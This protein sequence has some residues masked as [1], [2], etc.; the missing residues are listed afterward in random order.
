MALLL[1]I[2]NTDPTTSTDG[3]DHM[4][5][6]LF[7]AAAAIAALVAACSGPTTPDGSGT[8][9]LMLTDALT[10]EVEAVNIY[11]TS[12]TAKPVGEGPPVELALELTPN[13]VNLLTLADTV[14]AFAAAAVE[15]GAYEFIHINID[16]SRSHIV[17][18]G[19]EKALQ[20]PSGEVKILQG[21]TVE[22]NETTEITLD[23][24]ADASLVQLGNGG[25][26]LKPVIV[27]AGRNTTGLP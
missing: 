9:R 25:W 12:V 2:Q 6:R 8:L 11:F 21:F 27:H 4:K 22:E 3:G 7:L 26:L 1:R 10:D 19:V 17:E 18:A 14:T 16:A 15:P 23:F 5:I 13:P 20:V 24:D